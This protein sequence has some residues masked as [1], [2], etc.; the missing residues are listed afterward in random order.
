MAKIIGDPTKGTDLLPPAGRPPSVRVCGIDAEGAGYLV[1]ARHGDVEAECL[2]AELAF[3]LG[4]PSAL[5]AIGAPAVSN[6][7]GG[8]VTTFAATMHQHALSAHSG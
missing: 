3:Q 2:A 8:H 7:A 1:F 4:G 6:R 5:N